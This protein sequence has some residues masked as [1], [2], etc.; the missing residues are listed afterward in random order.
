MALTP[1]EKKR[2]AKNAHLVRRF[3]ITL[4]EYEQFLAYQNGRC[5]LC[6]AVP[7]LRALAV[8]HDHKSGAIRGLLC[9]RCNKYKVGNLSYEIVE[10]IMLYFKNP[11]AD[12]FFGTRR[13]VPLDM[14]NPPKRRRRK[15]AV[16]RNRIKTLG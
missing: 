14:I 16:T 3:G 8:D 13:F 5:A 10:S 4:T 11:P 7:N 6:P 1:E 2:R 12:E 15:R 9:L